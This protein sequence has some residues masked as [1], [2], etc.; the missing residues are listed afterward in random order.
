MRRFCGEALVSPR[1]KTQ[2][3]TVRGARVAAGS[4]TLWKLEQHE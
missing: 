3:R 4:V 1:I 2:I